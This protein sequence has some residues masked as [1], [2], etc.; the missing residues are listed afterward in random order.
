M[1]TNFQ[2]SLA[3]YKPGCEIKPGM[4]PPSDAQRWA[5][6]VEYMGRD[7]HGF[8][9][10]L[11][12]PHTIQAHLEVALSKVACEKIQVVCA[13]RTDTG[14]HATGQVVH[15]D[16]VRARPSKAWVLGV[17]S[18]LPPTIRVHHAQPVPWSF[19]ARFSAGARTYRYLLAS[20]KTP[21]A[22]LA[23]QVSW[24]RFALNPSA[25]QE[26]CG[27]FLGEHDFTSFRAMHCQAKNPVRTITHIQLHSANGL[28]VLEITANAF[29]H[30]MVRNIMGSLIDVGR[31]IRQPQWIAE[32]FAARDR[33]V[34][35]PTAAP[36]GLYLVA[37][38]YPDVFKLPPVNKGPLLLP[39]DLTRW[40]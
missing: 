29:L 39:N 23:D 22:T 30:H 17:N 16:T 2:S 32:V 6:V 36:N 21:S 27:F 28:L 8:A 10:Q 12:S 40:G 14:V 13:G 9:K 11:T 4:T 35:A 34:A 25:M 33:A 7:F 20:A 19:H 37:V 1:A 24:I 18:Y 38:A 3:P 5:L 15:F 26:A 31:G